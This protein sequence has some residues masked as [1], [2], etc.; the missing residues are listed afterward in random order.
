MCMVGDDDFWEFY[1][2]FHPK[3]KIEHRCGECRRTIAKGEHYWT[4]GGKHEGSFVW[5]KT[6]EHCTIAAHW[7]EYVCDGWIFEAR[8]EDFGSHVIGDERYIRSAPLT[9]LYRWMRAGW[10][11]R[12]GNLRSPESVKAVTDLAI[13]RY[14]EQRDRERAA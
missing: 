10:L 8:L 14:K 2:E 12:E 13:Q 7:L 9:R 5:H 11:D 3:A 1:N 4:Q 6:C